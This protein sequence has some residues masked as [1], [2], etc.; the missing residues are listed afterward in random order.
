[1]NPIDA[2][3]AMKLAG[4]KTA[5]MAEEASTAGSTTLWPKT[6]GF[7]VSTVVDTLTADVREQ[8]D[9]PWWC[10]NA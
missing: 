2:R 7:P 10:T 1:M 5:A 6:A 3:Y 8:I 4:G 9:G